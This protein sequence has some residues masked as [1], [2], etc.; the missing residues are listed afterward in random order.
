MR[1]NQNNNFAA[2]VFYPNRNNSQVRATIDF[3]DLCLAV[4]R[5]IINDLVAGAQ[6]END[7][8]RDDRKCGCVD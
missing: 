1:S 8:D 2:G 7:R 4:R 3:E 5:C 6:D